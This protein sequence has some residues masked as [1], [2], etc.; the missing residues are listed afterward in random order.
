MINSESYPIA[1]SPID[2]D[3][4]GYEPYAQ[5]MA[6]V[7]SS[8]NLETPFTVGIFGP[9]GTG[10]TTFMYLVERHLENDNVVF[11]RPWQFE[12][13][14]EVWKALI[15]TVLHRLE[16]LDKMR[17]S[18]VER[19]N[20]KL[21]NLL[22]GVGKLAL[23]SAIS[24][25]TRNKADLN[26]L[27]S[28]YSETEQEN[29]KFLNTFRREFQSAKN[30][31]LGLEENQSG[32]LVVFVDD[33]DRC[34]PENCIM[35]LEAIKLFFD[36]EGCV[37][38]L[39]IDRE[40]VQKGI[41]LK[42][43]A[44]LNI[45]GV[46]YLEK[47]IQ[48]PFTLPPVPEETFMQFVEIVA[49]PFEFQKVSL[50]LISHASEENPRRVKRLC[51]CLFMVSHVAKELI[52]QNKTS[53]AFTAIDESK[54]ALLLILQIRFP[55]A[56]RWLTFNPR[57]V[58]QLLSE[59]EESAS[60]ELL[61]IMKDSYGPKLSEQIMTEFLNFLKA[62]HSK[63]IGVKPFRDK[64]E[65]SDYLR[66][67]GVVEMR[68]RPAGKQTSNVLDDKM[69]SSTAGEIEK[70]G[71]D[72]IDNMLQDSVSNNDMQI[73]LDRA[74]K[75]ITKWK[76]FQEAKLTL[77]WKTSARKLEEELID[78]LMSSRK[79]RERLYNLNPEDHQERWSIDD[80]LTQLEIINLNRGLRILKST[81]N[82]L[83]IMSFFILTVF[84]TS[85]AFI[86]ESFMRSHI[87]DYLFPIMFVCFL[88]VCTKT[89]SYYLSA[90]RVKRFFSKKATSDVQNK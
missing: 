21:A 41:E 44:K 60:H 23:N 82:S 34:S 33:L 75:I 52:K 16:E 53:F 69:G 64:K 67:T 9:W 1:D 80:T 47:M 12:Q 11:F 26:T 85:A 36:F 63:T 27:V 10:K 46:D 45:R 13:K 5:T 77:L 83:F 58:E 71:D 4:L 18:N 14:E 40:V 39:G 78:I 72:S 7:L 3:L 55:L 17:K 24:T 50:D 37:F 89:L 66:I 90:Q 74:N 54:L 28:F 87:I 65:L 56:Y 29:T 62:V 86:S 43:D 84:S 30:D 73:G 51:N 81:G 79:M 8:T 59:W 76:S 49:S 19:Q 22:R 25:L 6:Q 35:V 2:Q 20:E 68:E 38:I 31:I 61:A 70:E 42:Y 57:T 48:L 15:Y 88:G 32:R